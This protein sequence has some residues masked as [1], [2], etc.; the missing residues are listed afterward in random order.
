MMTHRKWQNA[1]LHPFN[2]APNEGVHNVHKGFLFAGGEIG[3]GL[4]GF[5]DES[6]I[7]CDDAGGVF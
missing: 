1:L 7:A 2:V 6:E 3:E 5:G 4:E